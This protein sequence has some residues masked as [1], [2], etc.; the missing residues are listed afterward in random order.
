MSNNKYKIKLLNDANFYDALNNNIHHLV[1][2]DNIY[3]K[4]R[5][6]N[7]NIFGIYIF[8][9]KWKV[10]NIIY[11]YINMKVKL[12]LITVLIILSTVIMK[13]RWINDELFGFVLKK[14]Y[15]YEK[16]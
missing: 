16:Q 11:Q 3:R 9:L 4:A 12:K 1:Y 2:N 13:Y 15:N 14:I 10:I 8:Y 7:N 6:I 5:F